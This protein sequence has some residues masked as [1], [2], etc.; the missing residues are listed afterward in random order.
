MNKKFLFLLIFSTSISGAID[1]ATTSTEKAV[2]FAGRHKAVLGLGIPT[3]LA[4]ANI[5]YQRFLSKDPEKVSQVCNAMITFA[6]NRL[7]KG[8]RAITA[9]KEAWT[10]L[11]Q[12]KMLSISIAATILGIPA[13]ALVAYKTGGQDSAVG[14]AAADPVVVVDP[15]LEKQH[16]AATKIQS[17][18]RGVTTKIQFKKRKE[19]QNNAEGDQSA[20]GQPEDQPAGD[21]EPEGAIVAADTSRKFKACKYLAKAGVGIGAIAA[22]GFYFRKGKPNPPTSTPPPPPSQASIPTWAKNI[23]ILTLADMVYYNLN[24]CFPQA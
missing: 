23:L 4:T 17:L 22:I 11:M 16:N 12:N 1:S 10:I 20:A 3:A 6:Q 19:A 15:N 21:P 9:R 7:K 5:A 14:H 18:F 13:T 8:K 24:A 2:E